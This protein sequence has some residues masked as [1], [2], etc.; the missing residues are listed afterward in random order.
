V[1]ATRFWNNLHQVTLKSQKIGKKNTCNLN[2]FGSKK[3]NAGAVV[4]AVVW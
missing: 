3:P 1:R 2:V 4:V